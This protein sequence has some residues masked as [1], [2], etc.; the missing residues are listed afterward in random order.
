VRRSDLGH[1]IR[2]EVKATNSGG[3]SLP[4]SSSHTAAALPSGRVRVDR[5]LVTGASVR[6]TIR[7][8]RRTRAI[9]PVKLM[10]SAMES[11]K[12][13]ELIARSTSK[14]SSRRAK[15]LGEVTGS[16]RSGHRATFVI[17]LNRLGHRLVSRRHHLRVSLTIAKAGRVVFRHA[18]TFS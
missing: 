15:L 12:N 5:V 18:I 1:T 3:V 8:R 11:H 2:V 6:V 4:T 10:L 16:V 13:G 14:T 7:C 9:C 17:S